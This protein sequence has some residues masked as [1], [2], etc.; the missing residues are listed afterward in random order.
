MLGFFSQPQQLEYTDAE[1]TPIYHSVEEEDGPLM[2][3]IFEVDTL[4]NKTQRVIYNWEGALGW[5]GGLLGILSIFQEVLIK[6]FTKNAIVFQISKLTKSG[7]EVG[8]DNLDFY[9]K[10]TLK[11]LMCFKCCKKINFIFNE[12]FKSR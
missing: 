4:A 2:E 12:K 1:M 7:Q 10:K 3:F 11:N 9:F 6:P 8:I 5:I